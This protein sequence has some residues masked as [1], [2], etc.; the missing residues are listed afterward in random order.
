MNFVEIKPVLLSP[1][2]INL[3]SLAQ[4]KNVSELMNRKHRATHQVYGMAVAIEAML[5]DFVPT[6]LALKC[7]VEFLV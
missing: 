4:S 3:L 2:T 7:I 6:L 1:K 5:M